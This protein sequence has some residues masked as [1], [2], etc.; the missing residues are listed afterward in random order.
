[1]TVSDQFTFY[2]PCIYEKLPF[3][4]G[5]D[6]VKGSIDLLGSCSAASFAAGKKFTSVAF[7]GNT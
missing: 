2:F 1:M 7:N 6:S 5:I 4:Y 3:Y